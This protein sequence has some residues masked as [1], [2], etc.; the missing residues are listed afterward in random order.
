MIV[1]WNTDFYLCHVICVDET[2]SSY[3]GNLG[4]LQVYLPMEML[5]IFT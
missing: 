1:C 4:Y 5:H 2:F 3:F